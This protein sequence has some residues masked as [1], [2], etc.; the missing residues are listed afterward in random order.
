MLD[1]RSE[2]FSVARLSFGAHEVNDVL[3]EVGIIFAVVI[4]G[5]IGAIRSIRRHDGDVEKRLWCC[6]AVEGQMYELDCSASGPATAA[7][8]L[9]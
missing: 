8:E 2:N 9:R 3:C 1:Q 4:L 5:T 6:G 7:K